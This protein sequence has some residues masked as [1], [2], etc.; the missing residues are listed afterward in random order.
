VQAVLAD[1]KAYK[2]FL[3]RTQC[4]QCGAKCM[5]KRFGAISPLV[6]G[7]MVDTFWCEHCGRLLCDKHRSLHTC[8]RRDF[9]DA[10]QRNKTAA[11]IKV[12]TFPI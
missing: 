5:E 4:A 7:S 9:L 12:H 2:R 11:Q 6:V 8:E 1:P 3:K 10:K